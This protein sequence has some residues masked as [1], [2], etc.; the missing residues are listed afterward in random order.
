ML[1][2][3]RGFH[4]PLRSLEIDAHHIEPFRRY[5]FLDEETHR[6]A[7]IVGRLIEPEA[8]SVAD[9]F[10][11]RIAGIPEAMA[12]FK[13]GAAHL[14]RQRVFLTGW[15]RDTFSA[16]YD[17]AYVVSREKIGVVHLNAGV[18]EQFMIASMN[19]IRHELMGIVHDSGG[20]EGEDSACLIQA[21][22]RVLDFDLGIMLHAYWRDFHTR[23]MRVD[24]LALIGQF[25]AAINHELRNPLGVIGT[26][27]FLLREQIGDDPESGRHLEKIERSLGRANRIVSGLLHL[28]RVREPDR[29]PVDLEAFFEEVIAEFACPEKVTIDVQNTGDSHVGSFDPIQLRQVIDNLIRNAVDSMKNDGQITIRWEADAICT[30]IRMEDTGP[31][32][33]LVDRHRIFDPLFS[34]KSFGTGLGLSLA[35]AIVEGH[36]GGIVLSR[37]TSG[38]GAAFEIRIPHFLVPS[39]TIPTEEM[40]DS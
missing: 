28:L 2:F 4:L 16:D 31:G 9:L 39:P 13:G 20:A 12:I 38:K 29:Q 8:D 23:M 17:D 21:L 30:I 35:K 6:L 3:R 5:L 19:W 37:A 7:L 34:T 25:T 18:D 11:E 26:S 14:K 40:N 33:R 24:R 1:G 32:I 15:L 10:Y 27:A 22:N 36:G